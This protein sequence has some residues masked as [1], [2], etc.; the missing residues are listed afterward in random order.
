MFENRTAGDLALICSTLPLSA[1]AEK[2]AK[3][4]IPIKRFFTFLSFH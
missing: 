3:R 1:R 2:E 4:V